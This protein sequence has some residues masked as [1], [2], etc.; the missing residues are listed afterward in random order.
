[1]VA[2]APISGWLHD[3][4]RERA[5]GPAV[6]DGDASWSWVDLDEMAHTVAERGRDA[7]DPLA[8]VATPSVAA[9]AVIH[10]A[11]RSPTQIVMLNPRS[12]PAELVQLVETSGARRV[13]IDSALVGQLGIRL[14]VPVFPVEDLVARGPSL[15]FDRSETLDPVDA[16]PRSEFLVP[17]SGTSG[18]PRLATL[19]AANLASSAIAWSQVLPPASGWLLSLG[20][21]HVAGIAIVVRAALAGVPLVLPIGSDPSSILE[22]I[23]R[24]AARGLEVSHLSLVASQ[25]APLLDHLDDG[26]PPPS[27]RAV[28]LGGGPVPSSL[29]TRALEAGWPVMP[30]YGM[31]ET[32][33]GVTAMP[34]R[35]VAAA[36]WS[37]GRA[38]PGVELRVCEPGDGS[39]TALPLDHPGELHVRGPMVFAGY[40]GDPGATAAAIDQDGWLRTGDLGRIDEHGRVE[41][42]DRIDDLIVSG[43]ENVAPAEIEA[44]L[45]THPGVADAG[46]VGM[47]DTRWGRVP[48]A[49]VVARPGASID[50][51]EIRAYVAE[52]LASFK[53]PARVVVATGLPRT[54]G[55]KLLR[56]E[57]PPVIEVVP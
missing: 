38:L 53:V 1:M 49:V 10:A 27:I 2:G 48:A 8:L 4:A 44:V 34:T 11:L 9:V 52:R 24:G 30:T 13:A 50:P 31:T 7:H 35:D 54:R 17:T 28:L 15:Q 47:A 56:R 12:A 26:P 3:H 25:L 29:V 39:S 21:A 45:L 55:G 22:T 40:A 37:A 41:I 42:I 36:P 51:D 5:A 20:L 33:S 46:V 18:R 6:G 43:G 14:A 32:A 57:L 23:R 16:K 19:T